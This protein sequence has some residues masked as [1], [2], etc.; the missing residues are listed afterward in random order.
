MKDFININLPPLNK[1]QIKEIETLKAMSDDEI[2]I[3]D[4]PEATDQ[5]L[6]SGHFYY[7]NYLKTTKTDSQ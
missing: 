7:A 5:Q 1:E 6:A 3:D 2:N 4:I